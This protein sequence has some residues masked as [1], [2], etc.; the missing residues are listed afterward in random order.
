MKPTPF[1]LVL[2]AAF[3]GGAAEAQWA[4]PEAPLRFDFTVESPPSAPS[5]G[6]LVFLP[7]GGLLPAP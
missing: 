7:D 6:I 4:V 2:A 5:A 3:L 1:I